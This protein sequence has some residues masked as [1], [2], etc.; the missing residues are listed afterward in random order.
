MSYLHTFAVKLKEP[1]IKKLRV[2]YI[3]QLFR[4]QAITVH[5][6]IQLGIQDRLQKTGPVLCQFD[7]M[8]V[9]TITHVTI[10]SAV[11]EEQVII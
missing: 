3:I 2:K 9:S 8:T 10:G 1:V 7:K 4:L 11:S 5:D 6:R